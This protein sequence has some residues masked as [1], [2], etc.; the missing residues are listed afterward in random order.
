MFTYFLP[1]YASI[2]KELNRAHTILIDESLWTLG[3]LRKPT[4]ANALRIERALTTIAQRIEAGTVSL[5]ESSGRTVV[6]IE[7]TKSNRPSPRRLLSIDH[8]DLRLILIRH[9]SRGNVAAIEIV[10]PLT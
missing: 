5:L 1:H 4:I 10:G 8:R 7:T 9:F 6:L 3:R 2:S